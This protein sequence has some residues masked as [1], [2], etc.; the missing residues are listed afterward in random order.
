MSK[1]SDLYN[2]LKHQNETKERSIKALQDELA[3]L[4]KE[5]D[6]EETSSTLTK[7]IKKYE[8]KLL[9]LEGDFDYVLVMGMPLTS[10]HRSP[11]KPSAHIL[12]CSV[13]SYKE[14]LLHMKRRLVEQK[15]P[16]SKILKAFEDAL[17]V[18]WFLRLCCVSLSRI[19]NHNI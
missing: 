17:K 4:K 9:V 7:E 19:F 13:Q 12:V 8:A 16:H 18:R 6:V 2:S 15:T 14:T 11:C 5:D 1:V 10:F 3:F